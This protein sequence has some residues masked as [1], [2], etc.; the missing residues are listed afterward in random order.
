MSGFMGFVGVGLLLF[1]GGSNGQN[2][3]NL[4]APRNES[5]TTVN[6]CCAI[7]LQSDI[8]VKCGNQDDQM[9]SSASLTVPAHL[10]AE[11]TS[12]SFG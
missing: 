4:T 10:M 11:N 1:L 6:T 7:D 5:L 12:F 9:T 2:L 3:V 8:P